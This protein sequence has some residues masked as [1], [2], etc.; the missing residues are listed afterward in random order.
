MAKKKEY[1]RKTC[2]WIPSQIDYIIK[3]ANEE[4]T[5][6]AQVMRDTLDAG[7]KVSEVKETGYTIFICT[8]REDL[9]E[10]IKYVA[11]QN[12]VSESDVL[13]H[14]LDNQFKKGM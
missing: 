13:T 7:I 1:I 9:V 8:L 2:D 3:K 11:K 14:C 5:P 10:D 12:K 6:I 4:N